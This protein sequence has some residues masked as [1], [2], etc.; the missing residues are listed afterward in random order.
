MFTVIT[1]VWF[2]I[3]VIIVFWCIILMIVVN[4]CCW[5]II[6]F[7]SWVVLLLIGILLWVTSMMSR[8][9]WFFI[10]ILVLIEPIR[11][12][13]GLSIIMWPVIFYTLIITYYVDFTLI[14]ITSITYWYV[15]SIYISI[16]K[17]HFIFLLWI[18]LIDLF[19]VYVVVICVG[20]LFGMMC[21]SIIVLCNFSK[22][23]PIIYCYY[24]TYCYVISNYLLSCYYSLL[25]IIFTQT[26]YQF[27][28]CK[29]TMCYITYQWLIVVCFDFLNIVC[30][31]YIDAL[32]INMRIHL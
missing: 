13:Y 29:Y 23:Y 27:H 18:I 16:T 20:M 2:L 3:I 31:S 26:L 25:L 7:W 11:L 21:C 15:D 22:I 24:L 8:Y 28:M 17:I 12:V 14:A 10:R 30:L 6:I 4:I 1:N 5:F 32:L 19:Y 9:D